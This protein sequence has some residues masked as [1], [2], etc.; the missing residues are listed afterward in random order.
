MGGFPEVVSEDFA[1]AMRA[2][3]I[4]QHGALVD[5]VRSQESH[6]KD[7]GAF[8]TRWA[9]FTGGAAELLRFYYPRFLLGK[10]GSFTERYDAGL[11]LVTFALLPLYLV[12]LFLSAYLCHRFHE[13][14]VVVPA[15]PLSFLFLTMLLISA[16]MGVSVT[17]NV[18]DACRF[19]F[20]S[21]AV[22]MAA[23][24]SAAGR[25]I[26]HL[27]FRPEFDRTPK[28]TARSARFP[29][30]GAMTVLLGWLA[31]TAAWQWWSPF[32]LVLA[33]AGIA[34]VSFPLY[35]YLHQR[36]SII[37]SVA[38][39]LVYAPGLTFLVAFREMWLWH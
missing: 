31:L 28:G 10:A 21:Y 26:W 33:S 32:R 9:K 17:P 25:L 22:Y 14:G 1:F 19:W 13:S 8:V 11:L 27:F 12:N 39:S 23:L 6:P 5:S 4:G 20:W 18:F 15:R 7:F 3:S 36:Q 35:R 2:R 16:S 29:V 34:F 38:R 30:T 24:P 37:G